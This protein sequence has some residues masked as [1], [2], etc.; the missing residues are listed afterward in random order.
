MRKIILIMLIMFTL[1]GCS[2]NTISNNESNYEEIS[3]LKEQM[4]EKDK[5]IQR[6]INCWRI[7]SFI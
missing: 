2:K 7:E 1:V 4:A 5:E 3:S 6:L